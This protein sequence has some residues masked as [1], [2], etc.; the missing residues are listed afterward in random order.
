ML[1]DGGQNLRLD[2]ER[3]C[4]GRRE[5]QRIEDVSFN[6]VSRLISRCVFH[7]LVAPEFS[8]LPVDLTS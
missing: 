1:K 6:D 3:A 4:L 2:L 7:V 8:A 5:S